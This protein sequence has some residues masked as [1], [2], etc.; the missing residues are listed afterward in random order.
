MTRA[1]LPVALRQAQGDRHAMTV[2]IP[3]FSLCK[4]KA[5]LPPSKG[6][7]TAA[8]R[9]STGLPKHRDRLTR[10]SPELLPAVWYK[11]VMR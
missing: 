4:A 8:R 10:P 11:L 1:V 6:E 7:S 2:N 3:L 5:K 9:V